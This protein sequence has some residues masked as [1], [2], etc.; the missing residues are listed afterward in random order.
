MEQNY[1]LCIDSSSSNVSGQD[2]GEAVDGPKFW[3]VRVEGGG[4]R[5]EWR[6]GEGVR[7]K[8]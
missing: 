7:G 8:G 2:G 5:V 4:R 1:K 6:K 3:N